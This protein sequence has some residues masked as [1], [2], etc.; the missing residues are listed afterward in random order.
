MNKISR[1]L[2]CKVVG[3]TA[4]G[5]KPSGESLTEVCTVLGDDALRG[6]RISAGEVLSLSDLC[7]ARS[8]LKFIGSSLGGLRNGRFSVA[9]VAVDA[10][11]FPATVLHGDYVRFEGQAV[12]VGNSSMAIRVR[13]TRDDGQATLKVVATALFHMVCINQDLRPT[14]AVPA[15]L[16]ATPAEERWSDTVLTRRH[17][18]SQGAMSSG[19]GSLLLSTEQLAK[20]SRDLV[21]GRELVSIPSTEIT[22]HR[23]F[24]PSH[25]NMNN[26]VF[27]GEIMNWMEKVAAT[28][29]RRFA[30]SHN[31]QTIAM[32]NLK[33]E[34][35]IFTTDWVMAKARVVY[36][37]RTTLEVEVE[38]FVERDGKTFLSHVSCFV[39]AD[40]SRTVIP[41]G[42]SVSDDDQESLKKYKDACMRFQWGVLNRNHMFA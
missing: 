18:R 27:G 28:C 15:L 9:T 22:L 10:V 26:T 8:S 2:L 16:L 21:P 30:R 32:H 29:G 34:H 38:V 31:V 24:F 14:G 36:V 25:V 11:S 33:F 19:E 35:P 5:T 3:N 39:L 17:W 41:K 1:H 40:V 7:A 37:R 42:I 23:V 4:L 13:V 12:H 6:S 20:D